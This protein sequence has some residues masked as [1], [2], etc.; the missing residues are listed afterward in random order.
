MKAPL[1]RDA[2]GQFDAQGP[3][4]GPPPWAPRAER[5]WPPVG[6][7]GVGASALPER[8]ERGGFRLPCC[9]RQP[10]LSPL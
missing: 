1:L 5:L 9:L 8:S 6:A 10:R 7:P 3:L 2:R 4:R